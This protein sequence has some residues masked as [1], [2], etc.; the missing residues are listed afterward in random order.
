MRI[1]WNSLRTIL[2]K[3]SRSSFYN[4]TNMLQS[5]Y[6]FEKTNSFK[7]KETFQTK[8]LK[9]ISRLEAFH[10]TKN[11]LHHMIL[12]NFV[13]CFEAAV[14]G[15]AASKA[16]WKSDNEAFIFFTNFLLTGKQKQSFYRWLVTLMNL[17]WTTLHLKKLLWF[18]VDE[19]CSW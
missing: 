7:V 15:A 5:V 3:H 13:N 14:K 6:N 19:V 16:L 9:I 12:R 11:E 17:L 1:L 2:R 8:H 10:F 4:Y 18:M